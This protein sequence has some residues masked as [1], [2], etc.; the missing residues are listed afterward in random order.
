VQIDVSRPG[1]PTDSAYLESVNGTLRAECLDVLWF[2]TL[3]V[4][5]TGAR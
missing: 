1:K 4:C 2:A 3:P 5:G